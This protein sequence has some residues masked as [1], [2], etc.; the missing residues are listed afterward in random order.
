MIR[1]IEQRGKEVAAAAFASFGA[2]DAPAIGEAFLAVSPDGG[3]MYPT[4][5]ERG[6]D[7]IAFRVKRCPLKDAWVE[8]GVGDERL[9]TLCRVAVAFDRGLFE[10]TGVRF[11]NITWTPGHGSGLLPHRADQ[12][13]CQLSIDDLSCVEI[14]VRPS[15][16]WWFP[17]T[18]AER[19]FGFVSTGSAGDRHLQAGIT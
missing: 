15:R 17:R 13:R 16:K 3:L 12:S 2:N 7:R 19:A 5:V 18:G 6:D 10:A 11:D 4:D 9:A 1:A 8:A 14:Q